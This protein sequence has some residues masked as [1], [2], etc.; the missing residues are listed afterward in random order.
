MAG[1][2]VSDGRR[3]VRQEGFETCERKRVCAARRW[4]CAAHLVVVL[5]RRR[6]GILD[7]G[8]VRVLVT[9]GPPLASVGTLLHRSAAPIPVVDYIHTTDALVETS[10]VHDR[11]DVGITLVREVVA[12]SDGANYGTVARG[13][14]VM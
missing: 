13:S 4:C 9:V 10:V 1:G 12:N 3:R 5:D 14:S 7:R 8:G 2:G 6:V 11:K